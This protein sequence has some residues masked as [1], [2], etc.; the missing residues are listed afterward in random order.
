MKIQGKQLLDHSITEE[1]L[2]L[3]RLSINTSQSGNT[4]DVSGDT[5]LVGDLTVVDISGNTILNVSDNISDTLV[6]IQD[7][8]GNP[9]IKIDNDGTLRL[10]TITLSNISSTPFSVVQVDKTKCKG[11][12]FDYIVWNTTTNAYRS[13][14][15][16]S[17]QDGTNVKY[18]D[19][20][21]PDLN[22]STSGLEFSVQLVGNNVSLIA[23]ISSG[24]WS[25][26][27]SC[28]I[29]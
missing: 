8:I 25:M 28:R 24:I 12:F 9:I 17:I 7:T 21:T 29:L 11:L 18:N 5:R 19:M 27:I 20:S 15:I 23:N 10:Q 26:N 22:S 3:S 6:E 1:K 16:T 13:G 4:L 2:N 14:T